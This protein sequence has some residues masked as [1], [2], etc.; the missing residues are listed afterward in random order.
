[1]RQELEKRGLWENTIF[2][3][4]SEQGSSLPFA[5]WT[6]YINGLH[7]GLIMSWPAQ[8]KK[9]HVVKELV[10]IADITPTLVEAAGGKLKENDCDGKSFLKMLRGE[11]QKLHDYVY[12]AFTN[13]NIIGSRDRIFP[14]RV[15]RN[16][17]F[18]LIYNPNYKKQTSN[19]T[20]DDA[21]KMLSDPQLD[22]KGIAASWVKASRKDSGAKAL[23]HKLHHRPEYELYKRDDDPYEMT[24]LIHDPACKDMLEKMKEQLHSK[25]KQLNDAD[26]IATEKAIRK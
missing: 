20:L 19:T 17:T 7:T 11:K 23:V 24:N 18:T 10:S 21:L 13:C 12:G 9:G 15:I 1:M 4:C 8:A 6:C 22:G 16:S 5:K 26:P 25:L 3:V 2:A 14:I